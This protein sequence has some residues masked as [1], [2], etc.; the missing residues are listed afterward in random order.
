[1]S[2][3]VDPPVRRRLSIDLLIEVPAVIITFAMMVHI[4]LNAALRTFW[5]VPLRN[6]LEIT[7]Y[8]YV[9][10][11]AFLGFIAAQR[12]GQ[13]VSADLIYGMLPTMAQRWVK[14]VTFVVIAAISA[15]FAWYGWHEATHAFAI[16][17]TAGV[18]DLPAWPTYFLAPLAFGS[19]TCQFAFAAVRAWRRTDEESQT[20][21]NG[22]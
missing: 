15:G 4:S 13:H 3:A 20:E 8:W 12:R 16:R 7:Q 11:I 14:I 6:T 19:L 2:V 10:I 21:R 17:R 18:S 1:M 22:S 5:G 9:P